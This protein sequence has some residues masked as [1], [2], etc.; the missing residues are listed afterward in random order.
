[1]ITDASLYETGD[2]GRTWSNISAP[3]QGAP[4]VGLCGMRVLGPNVILAV[5]RWNG[6]PVFVKSTVSRDRGW[7]ASFPTL[8][9]TTDGG[10]TWTALQFGTRINRMRVISGDLVYACGDRVYRWMP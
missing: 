6:P 9:S 1:M 5:G 10:A 3:I 7:V 2:G 8:Y 4:V